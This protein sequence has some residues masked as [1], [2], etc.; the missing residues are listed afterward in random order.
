MKVVSVNAS[1]RSNTLTVGLAFASFILLGL[2]S[3]LIGV[4]W[5]AIRT[6]LGLALDDVAI[7]LF[8]STLGYLSASFASGPVAYRIGAGRMF[9][10][11]GVMIITGMVIYIVGASWLVLIA[12]AFIAGLGSGSIDAGLNAYIA[13]FHSTR[14]MNWLHA[15]FGIGVTIAPTIET[16]ALNAGGKW[17]SSFWGMD[18]VGAS[19]ADYVLLKSGTWRGGY[20]V[21]GLVAV[22]ITFLLAIYRKRFRAVVVDGAD[23]KHGASVMATLRLPQVWMGILLFV[24][25]AGAEATPGQWTFSLFTVARGIDTTTAGFW[26]T[27]Y[28]GSFT[29]GRMLFGTYLPKISN[30]NLLRICIIASGFG[31]LLLWWNPVT[32]V[33]LIGLVLLGF[34]QAPIFPVLVSETP[35][36]IGAAH[37]QNAVGF[38]V[39][40]AGLGVAGLP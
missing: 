37:S 14:A 35:R 24:F 13:N 19:I 20:I 5:P 27:V 16:I 40:G 23:A 17:V 11:G 1:N 32:A 7:L 22:A 6:E 29:I 12:A 18:S 9:A 26:V 28:W 34:G 38:Q 31:A 2:H 25:A 39:A 21:V 10:L 30:V 15:F 36:Y 3:G 4:A 33:G 8:A